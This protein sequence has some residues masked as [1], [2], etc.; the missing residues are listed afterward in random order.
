[1]FRL[2]Q[3][4]NLFGFCCL[5][6]VFQS[7]HSTSVKADVFTIRNVEVN[8]KAASELTAKAKALAAGQRTALVLLLKR[9]TMLYDHDKLP[10]ANNQLVS[11][12]V[13]DFS[14][15][16]EKFG[17]GRYLGKVNVR[18]KPK[19][20]RRLL[21]KMSIPFAETA[22]RP[23]VVLPILVEG[24]TQLLWDEPNSWFDMWGEYAR[25]DGLLP[26]VIPYRELSDISLISAEQA[27]GGDLAGLR[28][29]S[30][31]Y[32]TRGVLISIAQF[33]EIPERRVQRVEIK[34]ISLGKND[35]LD[36]KL[37]AYESQTEMSQTDFQ[38]QV[39]LA[40][41]QQLE[42]DWKQ[43]NLLSGGTNNTVTA[44]VP[45]ERLSDW[46]EIKKRL[47]RVATVKH[48][49]IRRMS[50][51]EIEIRIRF[52]GATDQL[53]VALEQNGL[54]LLAYP[55]RDVWAVERLDQ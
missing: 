18:F 14:V 55:G 35:R 17:G 4:V 36:E 50:V 9:I 20:V 47:G 39:V 40:Q 8:E 28:A 5:T 11:E 1:M 53:R 29:V 6:L 42:E 16:D 3:I 12:L 26:L 45:A 31:K 43:A 25:S 21:E 27:S 46:L 34:L 19:A 22:S 13:R 44:L 52:Q 10:K 32:K 24:D 41:I 51:R 7:V 49:E 15:A 2:L 38:K 30:E 23:L 33:S 37:F 54:G 48:V